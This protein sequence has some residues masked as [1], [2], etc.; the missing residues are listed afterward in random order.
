MRDIE[1][2]LRGECTKTFDELKAR[3]DALGSGRYEV[4]TMVMFFGEVAGRGVDLRCRVTNGDAEVVVKVGE[5]HAHNRR[6]TSVE[7][8]TEQMIGFARIFAAMGFENAKVGTRESFEYATDGMDVSLV[9][10]MSGLAY[11]EFEKLVSGDEVDRER[12][13]LEAL[14]RKLGV[15]LW[16]TGEEYYAFCKR[17]TDDEDWRFTGSSADVARLKEQIEARDIG[18]AT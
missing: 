3:L 13:L 2:E 15:R 7:V 17:L 1:L 5:Y 12:P 16:T 10:G 6:E 9:R 11:I 8:N 14:A 4:R 18:S